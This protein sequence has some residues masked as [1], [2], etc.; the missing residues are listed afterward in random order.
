MLNSDK[1]TMFVEV[2]EFTIGAR[3]GFNEGD[4]MGTGTGFSVSTTGASSL[5]TGTSRTGTFDGDDVGPD[6]GDMIGVPDGD[7]VTGGTD[8]GA[9]EGS[10]LAAATG[11]AEGLEVG[12]TVEVRGADV[13]GAAVTGARVEGDAV[14]GDSLVGGSVTGGSVTGASVGGAVNTS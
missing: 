10:A 12:A 5:P 6:V 9:G 2:V 14:T 11:W 8:T 13:I 1:A 3:D 4:L 7:F